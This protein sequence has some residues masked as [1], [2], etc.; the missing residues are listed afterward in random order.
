MA[1]PDEDPRESLTVASQ[2]VWHPDDRDAKLPD[3]VDLCEGLDPADHG[4]H[5][6]YRE[7]PPN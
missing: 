4:Y 6:S 7:P 5:M 3:V 1:H 2:N